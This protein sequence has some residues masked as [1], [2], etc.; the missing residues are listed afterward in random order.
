MS[1]SHIL[2][3]FCKLSI[4]IDDPRKAVSTWE[5][6][7][8]LSTRYT[9]P[10]ARRLQY[11][12]SPEIKQLQQIRGVHGTSD[13]PGPGSIFT[14]RCHDVESTGNNLAVAERNQGQSERLVINRAR[15]VSLDGGGVIVCL[16]CL[17]GLLLVSCGV[18]ESYLS[19]R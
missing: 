1:I 7:T 19:G 12:V 9:C 14:V 11:L 5:V 3:F 10:V 4:S 13:Q 17:P 15:H 16:D 18:D 6:S 8:V 2:L